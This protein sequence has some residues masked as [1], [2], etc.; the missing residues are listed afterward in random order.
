MLIHVA[1]ASAMRR[2]AHQEDPLAVGA[3]LASVLL[4]AAGSL[5]SLHRPLVAASI[6]GVAGLTGL[7]GALVVGFSDLAIWGGLALVPTAMSL[8]DARRSKERSGRPA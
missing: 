2:E 1:A 6:F 3:G 8:V 5:F 7:L 4:F